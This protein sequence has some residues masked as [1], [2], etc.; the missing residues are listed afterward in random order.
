M[1]ELDCTTRYVLR[2]VCTPYLVFTVQIP[3][4][5][6]AA[7]VDYVSVMR[8]RDGIKASIRQVDI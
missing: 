3:E 6:T 1:E 8:S 7:A 4:G 2:P 5:V